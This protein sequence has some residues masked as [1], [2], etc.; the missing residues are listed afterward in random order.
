[1]AKQVVEMDYNTIT[2]ASKSFDDQR[3]LLEGIGK[4]LKIVVDI[5]KATAFLSMGT[6]KA[7]EK[8]LEGIM[9]AVNAL[10]KVCG[11]FSGDLKQAVTEHKTGDYKGGNYFEKGRN[12]G[13]G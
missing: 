9:K 1:M 3:Q 10:A 2:Q 13:L 5:L 6:T 12:L 8:Y 7:L 11:E 4:A